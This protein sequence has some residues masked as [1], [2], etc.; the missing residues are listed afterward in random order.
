MLAVAMAGRPE[1]LLADE[2]TSALDKVLE[3][4]IL[5]LIDRQRHSHGLGVLYITHDLAT[6]SA[7]ADRVVVMEAGRVQE[8]GPVR[9]GPG[10][11]PDHMHERPSEGLGSSRRR[12][13][14][15]LTSSR[16][17]L[18]LHSVTKRFRSTRRG[19]RPAL[20]DVSLEL[21]G[22]RDP[23]HPGAVRIRQEHPGAADPRT[24]NPRQRKHHPVP[25]HEGQPGRDCGHGSSARLPGAAR[26][27]RPAH[28]APHQPGSSPAAAAGL[29]GRGPQLRASTGWFARLNS[30][31]R[32]W[33]GT[34]AN[35]RAGSSSGSRSPGRCCWNRQS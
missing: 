11:A 17:V 1:L 25:R 19:A 5:E 12:R 9:T 23:R 30:T 18:D 20:E 15:R 32:C 4:Q 14:R 7:F 28:E 8:S 10:H 31:L 24:R 34:P 2:P 22:R 3:R 33:T 6:V 21:P 35:A 13:L 16:T 29:H 26:C 27:L